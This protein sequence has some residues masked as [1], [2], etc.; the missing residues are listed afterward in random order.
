MKNYVK[1]LLVAWVLAFCMIPFYAFSYDNLSPLKQPAGFRGIYWESGKNNHLDLFSVFD[2]VEGVEIFN[3]ECELLVIGPAMLGEIRYHFYNNRFYQVSLILDNGVDNKTL[4]TELTNA[5]GTPEE[6]T[7]IYIWENNT[8]SIN[9]YPG[10][11]IISYLPIL[12]EVINI[13]SF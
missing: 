1:Y 12:N 2:N 9:L 8:V 4:L 7:G 3:R 5:F 13:N 6:K 10:G 11:A